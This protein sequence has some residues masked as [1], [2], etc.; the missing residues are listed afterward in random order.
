MNTLTH[1][2]ASDLPRTPA[3][4]Q[5][6]PRPRPHEG[7]PPFDQS[8]AAL[9]FFEFWPMWA[10]YPPVAL[11]AVW[12]ML[13]YR[14]ILLPTVA[15]PSFPGGGFVG[16]SKAQ[17]L[18]M[19]CRHAPDWFAP[20][21]AVDR[22]SLQAQAVEGCSVQGEVDAALLRL[23][24][25]GLHL[26][27]VA[28]PDLGCRGAG[29]KL[30]RTEH[31]LL[32]YLQAFPLGARLLLQ[33]YVAHEGEAGVFY[34]RLPGEARG[35]IVSITLKYFPHV[36]GDGR[37]TL[38]ELI[39]ADPRAGRL[40]HLYLHR[41][42]ARLD[43][44]PAE[45]TAIR[46]AFA[47]SHSRG[48]IFRDGS[49]LVTPA[50]EAR[51]EAIARALPEFHFGRFDIRFADFAQVQAGEGFTIVEVNG[52]GAES[53]HI[54]DRKTSLPKAWRDLMRQYRWLF[55]IGRANRDRGFQPLSWAE[56]RS[57]HRREKALTAL[58]PATD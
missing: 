18:E 48:A 11:Y 36:Y 31:D 51:F 46:L 21:I 53:T 30:V 39:L 34:R 54:W 49:H 58:Y 15:N 41:H 5:Q 57:A 29:V 17:I 37:R 42:A 19:A 40:P 12:L 13:R 9:S 44:V 22:P 23:R 50:M 16:E 56:F 35:Q 4:L 14:G 7:M 6:T 3:S 27:V 43:T 47:G 32:A 38:R 24:S 52:A 10:F 55:Q 1:P 26:P 2:L 8:G 25:A 20:F 28:K 45:G 33:R